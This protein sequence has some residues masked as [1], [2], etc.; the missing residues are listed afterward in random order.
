MKI[1]SNNVASA[2]LPAIS[3]SS[4]AHIHAPKQQSIIYFNRHNHKN[5]Q[6]NQISQTSK[7]IIPSGE[8][9]SNKND[10]ANL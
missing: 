3:K 6:K 9:F 1:Q 7:I 5:K 4:C 10:N 8:Y 2:N